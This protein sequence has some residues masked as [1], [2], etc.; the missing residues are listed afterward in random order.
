MPAGVILS[1]EFIT[2]M[3]ETADKLTASLADRYQIERTLGA[4]GMARVYLARDLKHAR[5]V[6][7]KVMW[8]ELTESVGPER[9]LREIR[10]LARLQHPNILGLVDSGEAGGLLYYIMPYLAGGS[11]R[12][13]L[14]RERELRVWQQVEWY[15]PQT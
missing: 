6:A 15:T 13:R 10:L 2:H 8:P 11:L 9:F 12:M 5:D 1:A 7:I 3:D 14:T 4:G